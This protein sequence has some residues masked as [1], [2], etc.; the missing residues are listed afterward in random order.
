VSIVQADAQA[1]L[2]VAMPALSKA[3]KVRVCA[4]PQSSP[5]L[6]LLSHS[7]VA[8][9]PASLTPLTLTLN[10]TLTL[11]ALDSLDKKDITEVKSFANPPPAVQ[12]VME[13][14]CI[15]LGQK[16][17]WDTYVLCTAGVCLCACVCVHASFV[18]HCILFVCGHS[19]KKVL[20][21]VNFMQD[22]KEFDKDNIPQ[23]TLKKLAKYIAD[24]TMAIENVTKVREQLVAAC[25]CG[26]VCPCVWACVCACAC[27]RVC[28]CVRACVR[29]Y[30]PGVVA[31]VVSSS[32]C[33]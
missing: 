9:A 6:P 5:S 31:V 2:D 7:L 4:V 18:A 25:V 15:L 19:A 22:L 30:L 14:V 21:N 24:Q 1:D 28:A 27:V 10:L 3:V 33:L 13:A 32:R 23:A 20:S 29:V 26:C 16:P 11:Q 12:V 17:D 8:V